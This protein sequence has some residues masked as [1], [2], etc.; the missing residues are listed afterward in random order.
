MYPDSGLFGRDCHMAPMCAL[1]DAA[2]AKLK[3]EDG[4][5]KGVKREAA[6]P[7]TTSPNK[8]L[9]TE[10]EKR[11]KSLPGDTSGVKESKC[12]KNQ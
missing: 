3:H 10:L 8:K 12:S 1:L 7:A 9:A 6:A 11:M 4:D 5:T 2:K